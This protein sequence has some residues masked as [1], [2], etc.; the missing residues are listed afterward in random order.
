[1]PGNALHA[2]VLF[3]YELLCWPC[4]SFELMGVACALYYIC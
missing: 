4:F 3:V 2:L 1:M